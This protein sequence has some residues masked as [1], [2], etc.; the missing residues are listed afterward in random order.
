M[1]ATLRKAVTKNDEV[2]EQLQK[3]QTWLD[4]HARDILDECDDILHVRTQLVYTIGAQ[5]L[6]DG[7]P[8]RWTTVQQ[9]LYLVKKHAFALRDNHPIGLTIDNDTSECFPMIRIIDAAVGEMLVSRLVKDV[10]EGSLPAFPFREAN[11]GLRAA[12]CDFISV[13]GIAP[14]NVKSVRCAYCDR[15][16]EWNVLLHLRG[17]LAYG[18]LLYTLTERRWRVHYGLALD[19]TMLAVPYRAKDVPDLRADFEHPDVTIVLTCLSYYYT[20]LTG[21]QLLSCFERLPRS[22]DGQRE[23]DRWI[24]DCPSRTPGVHSEKIS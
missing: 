21:R 23:Y 1:A 18:I 20:G 16:R 3:L 8:E 13:V 5:G 2:G 10:M 19:R 11:A 24:Q 9:L 12:I 6:L 7:H 15:Q 14:S 22:E 4:V 17:L